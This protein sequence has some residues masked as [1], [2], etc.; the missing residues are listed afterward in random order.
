MEYSTV[1]DAARII[2]HLGRDTLM[3]K[4]NIKSAFR[5]IP[6]HPEDR[7]VLGMQWQGRVYVD[8]QLPFG[9]R[10][11]PMLF[12]AYADALEWILRQEGNQHL[13]HYLDD[14]LLLGPPHS[15]ACQQDLAGMLSTCHRLGVPLA[16]DK[17]EGPHHLP[18]LP[19]DRAG[20]I[21]MWDMSTLIQ[22][23]ENFGLFHSLCSELVEASGLKC[24]KKHKRFEN[25][26]FKR[27]R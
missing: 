16:A 10:S 27:S 17:I 15:Q 21:L 3:A 13:I 26:H 1:E 19:R 11:A 9:L 24:R 12:N 23:C 2:A 25:N 8:T 7:T 4:I 14:F 6:V 20:L 18:H 5:I 22:R